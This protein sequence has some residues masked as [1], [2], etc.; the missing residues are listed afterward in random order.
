MGSGGKKSASMAEGKNKPTKKADATSAKKSKAE[1]KSAT[2]SSKLAKSKASTASSSS[3][4]GIPEENK[5]KSSSATSKQATGSKKS[6]SSSTSPAET[7]SE[8]NHGAKTT[9]KSPEDAK[10]RPPCKEKSSGTG[11]KKPATSSTSSS[12]KTSPASTSSEE[13]A[14]KSASATSK[15]ENKKVSTKKA[16]SRKNSPGASSHGGKDAAAFSGTKKAKTTGMKKTIMGTSSASASKQDDPVVADASPGTSIDDLPPTRNPSEETISSTTSKETTLASAVKGATTK[17][18]TTS[19]GSTSKP[20]TTNI[21]REDSTNKT[22]KMLEMVTEYLEKEQAKMLDED[23]S[24]TALFPGVAS[25]ST[26]S[27]AT[28]TPAGCL[29]QQ[30]EAVEAVPQTSTSSGAAVKESKAALSTYN[31]DVVHDV[32]RGGA[33]TSTN[34]NEKSNKKGMK[35]RGRPPKIDKT[36]S[37]S[38]EGGGQPAPRPANKTKS[39]AKKQVQ[40][41]ATAAGKPT[42]AS[43]RRPSK[44]LLSSVPSVPFVPEVKT[45]SMLREEMLLCGEEVD[46]VAASKSNDA[47][48]DARTERDEDSDVDCLDQSSKSMSKT[49]QHKMK[50]KESR[51]A[52]KKNGAP[53]AEPVA[54][55]SV[56]SRLPDSSVTTGT[57][58]TGVVLV[59]KEGGLAI[60]LPDHVGQQGASVSSSASSSSSS[61]STSTTT[62]VLPANSSSTTST[63]R[64]ATGG[65]KKTTTSTTSSKANNA[66]KNQNNILNSST[67]SDE[68]KR[69]QVDDDSDESDES[70]SEEDDDSQSEWSGGDDDADEEL[71]AE[72]RAAKTNAKMNLRSRTCSSS[73]ANST[74]AMKA[75]SMLNNG[76]KNAREDRARSGSSV[77]T[78]GRNRNMS[79]SKSCSSEDNDN[80]E[81]GGPLSSESACDQNDKRN[82]RMR[83]KLELL[84]EQVLREQEDLELQLS[85][86]IDDYESD[87]LTPRT[88]RRLQ[89]KKRRRVHLY[90]QAIS[91]LEE[92]EEQDEHEQNEDNVLEKE[93]RVLLSRT[94]EE[95]RFL[96]V[97]KSTDTRTTEQGGRSDDEG[98]D[99]KGRA[100]DPEE[101]NHE[102]STSSKKPVEAP[103]PK[104][105]AIVV[106]PEKPHQE[107]YSSLFSDD[108][109][110]DD[111]ESYKRQKVDLDS[112]SEHDS[113]IN[114]NYD[115]TTNSTSARTNIEIPTTRRAVLVQEPP[116][117]VPSFVGGAGVPRSGGAEAPGAFTRRRNIG[118][119]NPEQH[120]FSPWAR[121]E[122]RRVRRLLSAGKQHRLGS[123]SCSVSECEE[124]STSTFVQQQEPMSKKTRHLW[125][126]LDKSL[127]DDNYY[128][129]SSASAGDSS[130]SAT[131]RV[132]FSRDDHPHLPPFCV[133]EDGSIVLS[134]RNTSTTRSDAAITGA[135]SAASSSSFSS[136]AQQV[137]VCGPSASCS[138][139]QKEGINGGPPTSK[140]NG[141]VITETALSPVA[142]SSSTEAGRS[143]SSS[144]SI[145]DAGGTR[146]GASV[147]AVCLEYSNTPDGSDHEDLLGIYTSPQLANFALVKFLDSWAYEPAFQ[148]KKDS[149]LYSD[150]YNSPPGSSTPAR[151][152]PSGCY[153]IVLNEDG[154]LFEGERMRFF[155]DK[156][157]LDAE[158]R[159]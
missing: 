57:S 85:S 64:G 43:T 117:V 102:T 16:G 78:A 31:E 110:D 89:R 54:A 123:S 92:Q 29:T 5:S 124:G 137:N 98:G 82:T 73:S 28:T 20:R 138:S 23:L 147:F 136:A 33:T 125:R 41:G 8:A 126:P 120:H 106:S 156:I 81:A 42:T 135:S 40:P 46:A 48:D 60:E 95:Q 39:A 67:S 45:P 134:R 2:C 87:D 155:V 133:L 12:R 99:A 32:G 80:V 153:E 34:I 30:G 91:T 121:S 59:E 37:T 36:R 26:T 27:T 10:P 104:Q 159:Y 19:A 129:A 150:S 96:V 115:R 9:K 88:S 7:S 35:A 105:T 118:Q 24:S 109:E 139:S 65:P 6:S 70:A 146:S 142:P 25:S 144:S 44:E 18:T 116:P 63:S 154:K 69:T 62:T 113:R 75:T 97:G 148:R 100:E 15:V 47:D 52:N 71:S 94:Q 21:S 103:R 93:G 143:F 61:S 38:T 127:W 145:A 13:K 49:Q 86:D 112:H 140:S 107:N 77:F 90:E 131:S 11:G 76:T 68:K 4:K 79:R 101:K 132:A 22:D 72:V 66:G 158:V 51:R 114:N 56:D 1:S 122:E 152:T 111:F 141:A 53:A 50:V 14:K 130:S 74:T 55:P 151:T 3:T 17:P 149:I 84:T 157:R 58:G 108:E 119:Q 83:S 128:R